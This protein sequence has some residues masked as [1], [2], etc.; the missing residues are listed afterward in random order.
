MK[1]KDLIILLLCLSA[2]ICFAQNDRESREAFTLKLAVD[3]VRFYQ[4][5]V[6]KSKYFVKENTLQIYPGEHV[7][8]EAEIKEGIIESMKVVRE[9]KNPSK[10]IEIEFLQNTEEKE[11]TGMTLEVSNP[12]NKMLHYDAMMYIVGRNEWIKTSIIPVRS[13]LKSFEMWNDVII[14]LVL[15]NWR[16]EK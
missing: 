14:T 4:Q 1:I 9:N 8:V 6:K 2:N 5:E 12:F 13:K 3:S 16:L 15:D 7:F 11:N 10:T